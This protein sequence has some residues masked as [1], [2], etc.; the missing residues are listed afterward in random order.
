MKHFADGFWF[1][2]TQKKMPVIR[3]KAVG[4]EIDGI[5]FER[6]SQNLNDLLIIKL[7]KEHLGALHGT[8]ANVN[9]FSGWALAGSSGHTGF[10]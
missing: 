3:H 8:V 4:E 10:N 6:L 1:S 7:M 5:L 2:G 9:N